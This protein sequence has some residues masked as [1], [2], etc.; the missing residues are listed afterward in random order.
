MRKTLFI[1]A[2]LT[3]GLCAIPFSEATAQEE[4]AVDED[5]IASL[6]DTLAELE[7][8]LSEIENELEETFSFERLS[9]R[10]DFDEL[11]NLKLPEQTAEVA[12]KINSFYY[13]LIDKDVNSIRAT[14]S[15]SQ[16]EGFIEKIQNRY[17]TWDID[18]AEKMEKIKI[19]ATYE[20]FSDSLTFQVLNKPEFKTEW[21]DDLVEKAFIESSIDIYKELLTQQMACLSPLI[22]P[23]YNKVQSLNVVGGDLVL[24]LSS[25]TGKSYWRFDKEYRLKSIEKLDSEGNASIKQTYELETFESK[26]LIKSFAERVSDRYSKREIEYRIVNG[27]KVPNRFLISAAGD[28]PD[29]TNLELYVDDIEVTF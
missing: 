1:L 2:I 22:D 27:V 25:Q 13:N 21:L 6:K 18:I 19:V 8:R 23:R 15:D 26:Y 14:I 28:D 5:T 12:N 17:I 3:F 7:K 24:E 11:L 4:L 10:S 29:K 9:R 20:P 16:M